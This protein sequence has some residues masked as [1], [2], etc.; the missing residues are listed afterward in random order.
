MP[1][2][3]IAQ[4]LACNTA[5]THA[6][7]QAE[8]VGKLCPRQ[9]RPS[10]SDP[11]VRFVRRW[12][13]KCMLHVALIRPQVLLNSVISCMSRHHLPSAQL[14]HIQQLSQQTSSKGKTY[15]HI[16]IGYASE[17]YIQQTNNRHLRKIIAQFRTG[18]HWLHIGTGRHKKLEKEDRICPMYTH[19]RIQAECPRATI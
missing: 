13:V 2:P 16:K 9:R 11:H 7:G 18:S 14:Q 10:F 19:V 8:D 4:K 12:Q 15:S 3:D 5:C 17:P 6:C 1:V